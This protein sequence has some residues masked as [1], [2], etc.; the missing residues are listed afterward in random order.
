MDKDSFDH[1]EPIFLSHVLRNF[2]EET[3]PW[4]C[5]K[6]AEAFLSHVLRNFIEEANETA[7]SSQPMM[8]DS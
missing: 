3:F 2:I 1:D 7:M 6:K 5:L 8:R 4:K